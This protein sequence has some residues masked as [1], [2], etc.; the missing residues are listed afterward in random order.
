MRSTI[1]GR[2]Y[3]LPLATALLAA[4][5]V[6]CTDSNPTAPDDAE[7]TAAAVSAAA[8]GDRYVVLL[9]ESGASTLR[10]NA[11]GTEVARL[12]GRIERAHD[13]IGVLQVRNLTAAAAARVAGQ[14]DVE[15][16]V[17]DRLI[18][19]LPPIE[20][21]NASAKRFDLGTNSNQRGA[22]LFDLF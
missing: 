11:V 14:A 7:A 1:V 20:Q 13:E 8:S 2:V 3:N 12:G 9:K 5:N 16:V 10:A 6:G 21:R 22:I 15:A 19:W 4:V 17:K 18:R